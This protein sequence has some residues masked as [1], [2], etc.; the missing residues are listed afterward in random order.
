VSATLEVLIKLA[1]RKVEDAQ[2]TLGK[3]LERI[4]W[5]GDEQLRL[6]REAAEAFVHAVG[7]NDVMAL[8]VAGAFQE[9]MRRAVNVLKEEE[10]ALKVREN[11][12]R[13]VLQTHF[14][15]QKRYELLLEKQK[16]LAKK[17]RAKKQQNA[18][19]EVGQRKR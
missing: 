15:E 4:R 17:V 5:V 13:A 14:A 18:L 3:T 10:V 19:D 2:R 11:E 12:E 16:L 7:E 1:E 8:Q 6:E 9:R